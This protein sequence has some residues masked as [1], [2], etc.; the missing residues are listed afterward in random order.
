VRVIIKI[1]TLIVSNGKI[2]FFFFLKKKAPQT[3][4]EATAGIKAVGRSFD[5]V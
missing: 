5:Y 1:L 4:A 3:D 2:T